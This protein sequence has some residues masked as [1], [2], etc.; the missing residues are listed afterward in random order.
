MKDPRL[1]VGG[2]LV[3]TAAL[4]PLLRRVDD[5]VVH[6]GAGADPSTQRA[7]ETAHVLTDP[8]RLP[9]RIDLRKD[10]DGME[11]ATIV[12][13]NVALSKILR[14]VAQRTGRILYGI[15]E[16]ALATPL[17]SAELVDRPIDEVLE[18]LCGTAGLRVT[19]TPTVL[20]VEGDDTESNREALL[21]RALAR[22][23]RAALK[24]TLGVYGAESRLAQ[25]ELETLRGNDDAA[26]SHYQLL[27][28]SYPTSALVF[29]AHLRSGRILEAKGEWSLAVSEFR[30]LTE[31]SPEDTTGSDEPVLPFD[32]Y[33]PA[34]YLEI[35]RCN[36]ELGR[37]SETLFLL[38]VLDRN[39]PADSREETVERGILRARSYFAGNATVE[40][41][42][43]VESLE[44]GYMP[45]EAAVTALEI[46]AKSF[47]AMGLYKEA[48]RAWLIYAR[49][50]EDP[51][52]SVC[53]EH[54]CDLFLSLED[55]LGVLFL[56]FEVERTKSEAQIGTSVRIA[57][58][59][60][61]LEVNLD[62]D[63]SSE[64]ERVE[65]AERAAERS[66]WARVA[67]LLGPLASELEL[68]PLELRDRVALGY[69]RER[70]ATQG[71]EAALGVLRSARRVLLDTQPED[72]P[73]L[74]LYAAHLLEQDRLYDRALRAYDGKY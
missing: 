19:V 9:L 32:R 42:K 38:N 26:L 50:I 56:E 43:V 8:P 40:A 68:V 6:A 21:V 47:E 28:D 65:A 27:V 20:Q 35:A 7:T 70:Y 14:D 5:Q 11:Y 15:E 36:L 57:R 29:E 69:A 58:A 18:Y 59:A 73:R 66:D 67:M 51:E 74:D 48:A 3:V 1:I 30:A 16:F 17:V 37:S 34:A 4:V 2:A 60:L 44:L 55:Y 23:S 46:R 54:A 63:D 49:Q 61:G 64:Q 71:V 62:D 45:H 53:Y 72:V 52:R 25:G 31:L 13:S 39:W 33:V 24:D 12:G 10:D 22:Y 41:L